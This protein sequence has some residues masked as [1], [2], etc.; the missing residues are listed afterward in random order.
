M[1][2][3]VQQALWLIYHIPCQLVVNDSVVY[4]YVKL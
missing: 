3:Q 2:L 4:V 1:N